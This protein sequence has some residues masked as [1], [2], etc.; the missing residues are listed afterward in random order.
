M[1][2]FNK[3]ERGVGVGVD[4]VIS[5]VRQRYKLLS[6]LL[7]LHLCRSFQL[8]TFCLTPGADDGLVDDILCTS[9]LLT[10]PSTPVHLNSTSFASIFYYL[11]HIFPY[12]ISL[13]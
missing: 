2:T 3:M 12:D 10:L 6:P 13:P 8:L 5:D 9:F 7:S 11:S 1:T 4:G